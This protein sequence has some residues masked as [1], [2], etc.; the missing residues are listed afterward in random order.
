MELEFKFLPIV[1]AFIAM[2][3]VVLFVAYKLYRKWKTTDIKIPVPN[4]LRKDLKFGYYGVLDNTLQGIRSLPVKE[5]YV[6]AG[7]AIVNA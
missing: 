5:A 7:L 6:Q 4:E 2:L 3:L 1:I